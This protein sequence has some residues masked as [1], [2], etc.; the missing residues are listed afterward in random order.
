MINLYK[1]GINFRTLMDDL[2]MKDSK[3]SEIYIV[4]LNEQLRAQTIEMYGHIKDLQTHNGSVE[5]SNNNL[6]G[7]LKNFLIIDDLYKEIS[8]IQ[9]FKNKCKS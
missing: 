4:K 3:I 5:K 8:N 7:L 1:T 9:S 2:Q 6:K